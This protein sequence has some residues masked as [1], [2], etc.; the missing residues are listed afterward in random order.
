MTKTLYPNLGVVRISD[1]R[2]FVIADIPGVI[3]GAA[4][5][6]GLGIRFLKHL[7][8]TRL[9]LHLVDMAPLDPAM[10]P[11]DDV[12]RVEAELEKFG[13]DLMGRER[14]LV[15]NKK[16]LL[17]E[18][19][20]EERRDQI[21]KRLG[22]QGPVFE[23]SALTGEGAGRL[24]AALMGRLEELKRQEAIDAGEAPEDQPWDPLG[25]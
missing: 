23:V 5:G 10:D 24:M 7:A 25:S 19:E 14:W 13:Q 8:R 11:A 2:S 17:G 15:L 3:E 4:E 22:W 16:D 9:L 18:A 1:E 12:R 20:C 6:A 21:V